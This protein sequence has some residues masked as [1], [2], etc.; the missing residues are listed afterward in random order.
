MF[1][2]AKVVKVPLNSLDNA[3]CQPIQLFLDR[4]LIFD[5]ESNNSNESCAGA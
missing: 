2:D 5:E 4:M 1:I 3:V